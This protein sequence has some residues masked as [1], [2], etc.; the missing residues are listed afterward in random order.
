M[1]G[2]L[3]KFLKNEF[4]GAGEHEISVSFDGLPDGIYYC[5]LAT[6]EYTSEFKLSKVK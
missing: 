2:T 3:V 4:I 1:N 6:R 5:R